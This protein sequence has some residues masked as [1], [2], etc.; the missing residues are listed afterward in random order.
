MVYSIFTYP[1]EI[2]TPF[3]DVALQEYSLQKSLSPSSVSLFI[4][5]PGELNAQQMWNLNFQETSSSFYIYIF[6][7]VLLVDRGM[8]LV[9]QAAVAWG[10][11]CSG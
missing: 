6:G 10:N 2:H 9:P 4:Q 3:A 8:H 7:L 11:A 5:G 1:L